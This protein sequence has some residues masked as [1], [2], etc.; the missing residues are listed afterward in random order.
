MA[1]ATASH[2]GCADAMSPRA[3]Q[4]MLPRWV[5]LLSSAL[6]ENSSAVTACAGQ[7]IKEPSSP[8]C[9]HTSAGS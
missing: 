4:A 6:P 9:R 7:M 3:F 5:V 1:R 2:N 8:R